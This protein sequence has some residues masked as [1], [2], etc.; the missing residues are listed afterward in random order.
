MNT[1]V[2]PKFKKVDVL[3]YKQTIHNIFSGVDKVEY[4]NCGL[5]ITGDYIIVTVDGEDESNIGEIIP[6]NIVKSYKTYK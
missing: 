2:I 4:E 6:L 3:I 1:N 5:M